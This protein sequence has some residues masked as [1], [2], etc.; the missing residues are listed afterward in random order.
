MNCLTFVTSSV[1]TSLEMQVLAKRPTPLRPFRPTPAVMPIAW[2]KDEDSFQF[3]LAQLGIDLRECFDQG[4]SL[5]NRRLRLV[6]L[7]LKADLKL[8]AR[9]GKLLRW[10]STTRK[11]PL[12]PYRVVN[13]TMGLCCWLCPAGDPQFPYEEVHTEEPAWF[14]AM[15][16]FAEPPWRVG[17]ETGLISNSLRYRDRPAKFLLPDLFH[18]YLAG[19]GQDFAG[20]ALVYLLPVAFKSPDGESVDAQLQILNS[21]FRLWKQMYK[22]HT[23]LVYFARGSLSFMD[24]TKTF[25]TGTWSKASDTAKIISF[26]E[27][28]SEMWLQELPNDKTLYYLHAASKAI[29][30]SMRCLYDAD[31]FV[32]P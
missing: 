29:G 19:F 22:V 12:D 2:H 10:Y 27:H 11:A 4:V 18:I 32:D 16:S 13:R 3:M 25:P 21:C 20:S 1:Y 24:A 9:A 5:G 31:L 23:H 7:G 15:E 28:I 8:Q 26:I 30:V 6:L 17:E 14:K